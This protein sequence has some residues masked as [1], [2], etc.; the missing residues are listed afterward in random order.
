SLVVYYGLR[1]RESHTASGVSRQAQ[2]DGCTARGDAKSAGGATSAQ[3]QLYPPH[4]FAVDPYRKAR[5]AGGNGQL[6]LG[7]RETSA[8]QPGRVT[9]PGDLDLDGGAGVRGQLGTPGEGGLDVA[10]AVDVGDA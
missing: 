6:A 1:Q 3:E 8:G 5:R 2:S 7:H 10:E 9:A 4:R